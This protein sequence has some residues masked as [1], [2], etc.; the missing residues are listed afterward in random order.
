MAAPKGGYQRL[1]EAATGGRIHAG[2]GVPTPAAPPAA[3]KTRCFPAAF[4][5][6]NHLAATK[7]KLPRGIPALP[8]TTAIM[9]LKSAL[10]AC[11]VLMAGLACAQT[12]AERSL[13]E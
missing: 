8:P 1:H 7:H 12:D 9:M 3:I 11:L 13:G 10:L 5:R 6:A 4:H 2:A